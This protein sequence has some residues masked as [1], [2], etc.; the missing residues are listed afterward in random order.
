VQYIKV[1]FLSDPPI[2]AYQEVDELGQVL[3]YLDE[4][5]VLLY[6]VP[7]EAV[8]CVVTDPDPP[9]QPWMQ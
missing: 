2:V 3:R 6:E 4:Q 7:P 8:I 9:R 1:E 5:G